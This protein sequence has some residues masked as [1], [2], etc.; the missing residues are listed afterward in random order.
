MKAKLANNTGI[1]GTVVYRLYDP[2]APKKVQGELQAFPADSG[3][4]ADYA[5]PPQ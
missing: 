3:N 4:Q 1:I 5:K 2:K